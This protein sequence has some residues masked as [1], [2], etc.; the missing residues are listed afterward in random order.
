LSIDTYLPARFNGEQGST[1]KH[2]DS[3][4]EES[5]WHDA[6]AARLAD[7]KQRGSAVCL[8]VMDFSF[9]SI[10]VTHSRV[11]RIDSPVFEFCG[12]NVLI[13]VVQQVVE[14]GN[15]GFFNGRRPT[16][17]GVKGGRRCDVFSLRECAGR[18][19]QECS[20]QAEK[21]GVAEL[22][23]NNFPFGLVLD[24]KKAQNG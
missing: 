21:R 19:D 24:L 8:R 13:I 22:F 3:E 5:A 1:G 10:L 15:V 6:K 11:Q 12:M 7:N 9:V 4:E 17:S 14:S 2:E 20:K 16:F 18:Q 23:Q